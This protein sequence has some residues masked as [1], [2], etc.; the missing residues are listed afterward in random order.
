MYYFFSKDSIIYFIFYF[1]ENDV[2]LYLEIIK[3]GDDMKNI[4]VKDK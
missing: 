3:N 2:I 4:P 1:S